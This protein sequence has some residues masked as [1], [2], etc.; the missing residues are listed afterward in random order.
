MFYVSK[1]NEVHTHSIIKEELA[2]KK[3]DKKK[4]IVPKVHDKGIL[5]CKLDDFDKMS[6]GCYEVLEPTNEIICDISGVDVIIV[7]GIVFDKRK[8]RIGYGKG[9]YD[10]LLRSTNAKKIALAYDFQIVDSIPND[11]WDEKMDKVISD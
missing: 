8:H 11:E 10:D 2:K 1:G 9:Y 4:I 6:F 3:G 5:C 7:P